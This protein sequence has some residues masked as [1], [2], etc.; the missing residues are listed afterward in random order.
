[1]GL[2]S[3]FE[4]WVAKKVAVSALERVQ[5]SLEKG[6]GMSPKTKTTVIA[7]LVTAGAWLGG[8]ALDYL[9][10]DTTP[11]LKEGLRYA[12]IGAVS[13]ALLWARSEKDKRPG[14][15]TGGVPS[16]VRQQAS[17]AIK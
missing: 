17:K 1:M 14:I 12:A 5:Q 11:T 15:E 7:V 2:K 4:G 10:T 8:L 6:E 13:W 9:T 3:W 16:D